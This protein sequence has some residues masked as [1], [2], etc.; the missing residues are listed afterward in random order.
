[1]ATVRYTSTTLARLTGDVKEIR[2]YTLTRVPTSTA[3][4]MKDIWE[5]GK[6]RIWFQLILSMFVSS[7]IRANCSDWTAEMQREFDE[8][9]PLA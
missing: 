1:M 6:D 7:A 4:R 2:I 8:E 3:K 5:N 9:F